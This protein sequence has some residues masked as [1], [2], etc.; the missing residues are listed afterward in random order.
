LVTLIVFCVISIIIVLI[1]FLQKRSQAKIRRDYIKHHRI[2]L[3]LLVLLWIAPI[4]TN[5]L[6]HLGEESSLLF[7]IVNKTAFFCIVSSTGI[8][9]VVRMAF[10][11]FLR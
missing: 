6:I 4:W 5:V 7:D 11:K 2:V 9:N 1:S 3:I 8:I 10:D